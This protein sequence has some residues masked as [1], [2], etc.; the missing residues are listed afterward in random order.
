MI[1]LSEEATLREVQRK[2]TLLHAVRIQTY[3][4]RFL[5]I[6]GFSLFGA[7]Y[8]A[9]RSPD[10]NW[11]NLPES[12]FADE[13]RAPRQ[14]EVKGL[15]R[16]SNYRVVQVTDSQAKCGPWY[17]RKD[18]YTVTLENNCLIVLAETNPSALTEFSVRR[19][20]DRNRWHV[21]SARPE[22]RNIQTPILPNVL[23]T[24]VFSR[25]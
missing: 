8:C 12:L 11:R 13:V 15:A 18:H 17:L 19:F 22:N 3:S 21:D 6:M 25:P 10:L 16:D 7:G 1:D 14:N 20:G 5:T 23:P 2:E 24:Y 4:A 9:A